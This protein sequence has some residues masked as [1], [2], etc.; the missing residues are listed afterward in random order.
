ME[1]MKYDSLSCLI[2]GN[3]EFAEQVLLVLGLWSFL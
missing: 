1:S 2:M 3:E